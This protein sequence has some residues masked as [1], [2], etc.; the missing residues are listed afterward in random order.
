VS[1]Y[2]D[3][4]DKA[5]WYVR[6]QA[7]VWEGVLGGALLSGALV[8]FAMLLL[9]RVRR[10]RGGVRVAGLLILF[11]TALHFAWLLVPAFPDQALVCVFACGALV[12]LSAVSLLI[13][14]ALLRLFAPYR[15]ADHAQ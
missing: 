5:S 6:R 10:S 8:P 11:G 4:P 9:E 13:G 2:G 7:L 15:E 12:I 1:W 3:L 14:S